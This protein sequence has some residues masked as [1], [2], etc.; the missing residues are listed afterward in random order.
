MK[1]KSE[2]VPYLFCVLLFLLLV[3]S[4]VSVSC[5]ELTTEETDRILELLR[6][7][8]IE[9]QNLKE[10]EQ[11]F[12]SEIETLKSELNE[13]KADCLTYSQELLTTSTELTESAATI[14]KLKLSLRRLKI[15]AISTGGAALLF[16]VLLIISLL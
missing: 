9:L 14:Q 7:N 8:G 15:A 5:T 13:L 6:L 2:Y 16:L 12:I 3:F 11:R 1:W 10:Q 4:V